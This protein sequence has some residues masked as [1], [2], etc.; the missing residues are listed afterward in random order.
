MKKHSLLTLPQHLGDFSLK[1][2]PVKKNYFRINQPIPLGNGQLISAYWCNTLLFSLF[3]IAYSTLNLHISL[4]KRINEHQWRKTPKS[5][6]YVFDFNH[7]TG[8]LIDFT[9]QP[10]VNSAQGTVLV[11]PNNIMLLSQLHF[12]S[13]D[14]QKMGSSNIWSHHSLRNLSVCWLWKTKCKQSRWWRLCVRSYF[15][16]IM[17]QICASFCIWLTNFGRLI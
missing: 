5:Y 1:V 9:H 11:I 12:A 4:L 10:S 14:K 6:Q 7:T 17:F 13:L 2:T 3:K 15:C 16:L 8:L